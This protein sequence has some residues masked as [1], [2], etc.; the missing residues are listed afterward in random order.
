MYVFNILNSFEYHFYIYFI[1]LGRL[2]INNPKPPKFKTLPRINSQFK[3]L[4]CFLVNE[5][6]VSSNIMLPQCP[7][8]VKLFQVES[9]LS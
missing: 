5:T 8:A 2:T 6:W 3:K 9:F 4:Q 7:T 1:M